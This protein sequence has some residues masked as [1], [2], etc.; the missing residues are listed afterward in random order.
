MVIKPL[1]KLFVTFKRL[2]FFI[3][4]KKDLNF[5]FK[6]NKFTYIRIN[7]KGFINKKDNRLT[8]FI[9]LNAPF[10]CGLS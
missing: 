8:A 6:K 7:S 10:E 4:D 3:L 2:F 1:E 5:V 9:F